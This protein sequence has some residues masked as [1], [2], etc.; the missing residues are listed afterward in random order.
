[1]G[2]AT[3]MVALGRIDGRFQLLS[4]VTDIVNETALA[5]DKILHACSDNP[6]YYD[7][8][9]A[10]TKREFEQN[11]LKRNDKYV[12][13]AVQWYEALPLHAEII[14]ILREEIGNSGFD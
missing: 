5:C 10:C 8:V 9:G 14:V 12:S 2:N 6:G 3:T 7:E 4:E 11:L 13:S 1:M